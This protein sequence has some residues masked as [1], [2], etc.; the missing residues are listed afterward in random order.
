MISMK[1]EAAQ[2]KE[3]SVMKRPWRSQALRAMCLGLM[4]GV[5]FL[6][7]GDRARATAPPGV[8]IDPFDVLD[9]QVKNNV[10]FILDTS[11]SMKW[12][13]NI[14][15]YS[16]GGDDPVSRL[17]QAK[18]AINS[19]V[20]QNA[21][22]LNV[23]FA[24]Y[25]I[26]DSSKT[27]NRNQSFDDTINDGPFTYVSA[28][29]NAAVL[30]GSFS[31]TSD[32]VSGACNSVNGYFCGINETFANYDSATAS[33]EI[34]RSF[35]NG[36]TAG[37]AAF[38]APYPAG[39][40]SGTGPLSPVD[41][42]VTMRCRYY[43]ESRLL[44]NGVKYVWDM[45]S[46]NLT[47]RLKSQSTI[48]CPAP[49]AGLLGYAANPPVCFQIQADANS[50]AA[51]GPISTY[52]YTSALF[53]SVS[54]SSFCGGAAVLNS[55][56]P[57]STDNSPVVAAH[58]DPELPVSST[59][60]FPG[61][62]N[63]FTTQDF[64]NSVNPTV[65]GVRADQSTPLAGSLDSIRTAATP[66][67]PAIGATG[68]KNFVIL[69]TDGDDTCAD[70]SNLDHS[71][72]LAAV[73]ASNLYFQ[74]GFNNGNAATGFTTDFRHRAETMVVGF[75]AAVSVARINVIAQGGSGATINTS[76]TDPT[77]AVTGCPAGN[78]CRNA[79]TAQNT[80]Q[81]VDALSNALQQA[82]S[83]GEFSTTRS[84][85]DAIP[86]YAAAV[87]PSPSPSPTPSPFDPMNPDNRYLGRTFRSYQ[88]TFEMPAFKGH[89]RAFA[90]SPSPTVPLWDAGQQL[91]NRL[92]TGT[93]NLT[94]VAAT[95][96]QLHG[97]LGGVGA[98]PFRPHLAA[99]IDRRVFTNVRNGI[100]PGRA[101]LWPPDAAVAPNDNTTAGSL[102][103]I[104]GIGPNSATVLT[105][106][107]L[108]AAPFYACKT[109]PT[110]PLPTTPTQHP[111]L[112][113][114]GSPATQ[115]LRARREAREMILAFMA[116]AAVVRNT[117]SSFPIRTA[118]GDLRYL[119]LPWLL[120]EDTLG[121]MVVVT[122]PMQTLP[123]THIAEYILMR[124]GVRI[125]SG[126]SAGQAQTTCLA[127]GSFTPFPLASGTCLSQG[128][129]LRNPDFDG[130]ENPPNT[131]GTARNSLK[132]V[133]SV[134][135]VASNDMLHAFRAGP[136]PTSVGS[137]C[138]P[139]SQNGSAASGVETGGEELWGFVPYDLLPK[140]QKRMVTQSRDNH[141]FMLAAGLRF[142][143]V[144]VPEPTFTIEGRTYSGVWRRMLVFG[145]GLGARGSFGKYYTALDITAPGPFTISS[146]DTQLPD[147]WWS[148]GNP[149][150]QAI[151]SATNNGSTTDATLFQNMG[152]TWSVPTIARVNPANNVNPRLSLGREYVVYMGSGYGE[153]ATEGTRFYTL[154]ALTG[155][156]IASADVGD[157]SAASFTPDFDNALVAPPAAYVP[158]QTVAGVFLPN[159][160]GSRTSAVY[161]GDIHG[162]LWKFDSNAPG[163]AVLLK[164]LGRS[165][166]IAAPAATMNQGN[167]FVFVGTGNDVRVPLPSP[168][169]ASGPFEVIG[170]QDDG[171][172][173]RTAF[174]GVGASALFSPT[175]FNPAITQC[176]SSFDTTIL[177]I[178]ATNG[179]TVYENLLLTG[180][181]AVSDVKV[182]DPT[183]LPD[184]RDIDKGTPGAGGVPPPPA[185]VPAD[186]AGTPLP[187]STTLVSP[188]SSVC[189]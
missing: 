61:V 85:F 133:M 99:R 174:L 87:G 138:A 101:M 48:T 147:V 62:T 111:C 7:T 34:W 164:D 38:S 22:R 40:T 24:T 16:I 74:G 151:N 108:Q 143:E 110:T 15:N 166:P 11:G 18:A 116:G 41:L 68:Q 60:T 136:C 81:L 13:S 154:D 75:A 168:A 90:A 29:A 96:D 125:N 23:G 2:G 6:A 42:S 57:C 21:N 12:P 142:A 106:T 36:N 10:L 31:S 50:G 95:F 185:N 107:Q 82:A 19:V 177:V 173:V 66:A 112:I 141:T 155:D 9:L 104:L 169:P 153:V 156:V 179:N 5:A 98:P 69:V 83:A 47:T 58:L 73:A 45:S 121:P 1:V 55:V 157:G 118:A 91:L 97:G 103:D 86:E 35:G 160:A 134:V 171:V 32:S 124:D 65:D 43:M 64:M 109:D 93:N 162:R 52:Y 119:A 71:A 128:F 3:K 140:L 139:A 167:A 46:T 30:Y 26:L 181:K 114:T 27:L 145:R 79:F 115:L 88:T 131:G 189:R 129:G 172:P 20:A 105:F 80:Q 176:A 39:C 25:N 94:T 28:D 159:P 37:T 44:R 53:Q 63:A 70:S 8:G 4:A 17:F 92:E 132:P 123:L 158:Q 78:P 163:T 183:R 117:S 146:L 76:S 165:Q 188:A 186:K 184:N 182:T 100:V 137:L 33:A 126:G 67:F 89:L 180:M 148:R 54:G 135:Y 77:T 14:D 72:V 130:Q 127:Q 161:I 144:F 102:D 49:P 152:Q 178:S 149:D 187:V 175:R 84:V 56:A 122:P 113:T 170:V 120:A 59:G 150:V 51:A